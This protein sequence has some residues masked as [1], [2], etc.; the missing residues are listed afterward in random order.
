MGIR[1]RCCE[2]GCTTNNAGVWLK[3]D[4]ADRWT[5]SPFQNAVVIACIGRPGFFDNALWVWFKSPPGIRYDELST[6]D[7][8]KGAAADISETPGT[9]KHVLVLL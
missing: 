5:P 2:T 9:G 6:Y 8:G 7:Q 4:T 3:P 1:M